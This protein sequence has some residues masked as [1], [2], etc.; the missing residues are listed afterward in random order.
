[1]PLLPSRALVLLALAPLVLALGILFDRTLLWPMLATD[2]GIV[3]AALIDG[4][5]AF[6]RQCRVRR[7]AAHRPQEPS[8]KP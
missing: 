2:A 6:R 4:L 7:P 1:M 5:L 3:L 8:G